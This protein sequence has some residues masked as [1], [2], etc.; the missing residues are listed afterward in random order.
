MAKLEWNKTQNK[1]KKLIMKE[2]NCATDSKHKGLP[3]SSHKG[4]QSRRG[5]GEG[6]GALGRLPQHRTCST[7]WP[8]ADSIR[9]GWEQGPWPAPHPHPRAPGQSACRCWAT[10]QVGALPPQLLKSTHKFFTPL[11][12]LKKGKKSW[13]EKKREKGRGFYFISEQQ[14]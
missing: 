11:F 6:P 13:E 4:G 8:G 5:E 10:D 7:G 9:V 1:Q 2:T 12:W 3:T 14:R